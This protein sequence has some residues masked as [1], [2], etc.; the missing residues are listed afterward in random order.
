MKRA[1][2]HIDGDGFFA[3][4]EIAL[5]PKLKGK[6]VVTGQERGIA[7]AMS[8]EAK[9]LGIH[10]GMPVYQIKKLYPEVIVVNSNYHTY[11][12]FAQRMY[13]IVRRFTDR[14][15]EY[16]IDEC[17]AD[18]TGLERENLSYE[19]IARSI[20]E[21]LNR[22]LGMT[23]S[24]G[25]APTKV[26]AK[27]ASKYQKPDGFTVIE[28]SEIPDFLRDIQ[29]GQVWGIGPATSLSL[30]KYGIKTAL[31]LAERPLRW[32]DEN[33]ARPHVEIWH[34]LRGTPV[35]GVRSEHEDDQ[36]SLQAT[37]TFTPPTTDEA[38]ILSELS[39]NVEHAAGKAR[40]HG[41]VAKRIYYF[42]KTQEFRY[43]RMEIPL[44][45]AL[46]APNE[47]LNEIRK[48]FDAVYQP[49]VLYRATGVTLAGLVPQNMA[50]SD[51][52]GEV[53]KKQKWNEVFNTVDNIDRRY[54]THTVTLASS[55]SANRARHQR[56]HKHLIIP[57]M[58]ETE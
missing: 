56:P 37:R 1:I 2:V 25:L 19:D 8:P 36:K 30:Y 17:F 47:I 46:Q 41:L 58:G 32:V 4:C 3:S 42:L 38:H 35:Y 14:V 15:E 43:H 54:G 55:L 28:P 49:G 40:S 16:S 9:R 53:V 22:E 44:A 48:T 13:D 33:L 39:R 27:V 51:L 12:M 10:R 21:T 7:T 18:I 31:D 29:I 50:Q 34:E 23:F 5:N 52:F 45:A 26:V 57:F 20:K 6:P 11:G 24:L